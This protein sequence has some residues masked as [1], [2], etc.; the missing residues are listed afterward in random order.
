MAS[1]KWRVDGLPFGLGT[2]AQWDRKL[3]G[4]LAQAV[5]A[6][7]A[8]K[9]VEIG[10]GFEAAPADLVPKYTIRLNSIATQQQSTTLGYVRPTNICGWVGSGHDQRSALDHPRRQETISTLR[11]A[12][13]SVNLQTK[14]IESA[15]YERSD[16]CAVPAASVILENVVAFEIAAALIDKFGGDSLSEMR[17]RWDLFHEMARHG[18][19]GTNRHNMDVWLM[20]PF[21]ALD[22]ARRLFVFG[23]LLPTLCVASW[24]ISQRWPGAIL[25]Q[26]ANCRRPCGWTRDLPASRNPDRASA[27]LPT[28][29]STIRSPA[30]WLPNSKGHYLSR[31]GVAN[32]PSWPINCVWN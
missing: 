21:L 26:L 24:A 20:F 31:N 25:A 32:E 8:I 27:L 22:V 3:D 23:C 30:T 13:P 28:S 1:S 17:A 18:S 11:K 4:K 2:H 16:V 14:E 15:E 7:Q 19:R 12:L 5:M 9:G 6:V 10:L 29:H